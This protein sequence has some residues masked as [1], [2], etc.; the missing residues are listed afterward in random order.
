MISTLQIF[1]IQVDMVYV[2]HSDSAVTISKLLQSAP[3][4]PYNSSVLTNAAWDIMQI[5]IT[6]AQYRP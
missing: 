4:F 3:F 5:Q 1:I 6:I 2:S